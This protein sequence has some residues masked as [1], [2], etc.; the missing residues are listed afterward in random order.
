MPLSA[1]FH[2][3]G[4]EVMR[5]IRKAHPEY[6]EKRSKS[7]FYATANARKMTPAARKHVKNDLSRARRAKI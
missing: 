4:K 2:G 7:M 3:K 6:S 5:S 1:Y